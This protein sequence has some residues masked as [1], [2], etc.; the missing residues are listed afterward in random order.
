MDRKTLCHRPTACGINVF[1]H[2]ILYILCPYLRLKHRTTKRLRCRREETTIIT[3]DTKPQNAEP[4]TPD[5]IALL[6]LITPELKEQ[7]S[8]RSLEE[9]ARLADTAGFAAVFTATQARSTPDR[10]TYFGSGKLSEIKAAMADQGVSQVIV[11]GELSPTQIRNMEEALGENAQVIDRTMLI[12]DIFARHAT[13][14]E[15]K[16]QVEIARLR[17]TAPRL[18]GRGIEMSRMGGGT[19]SGF[20]AHRGGG[21]TKLETDRRHIR[22]R[23][24]TLTRELEDMKANRALVR[25]SRERSGLPHVA[26][27]GY[28]NCGK[29]TLL[30]K[31]TGAGVLAEDKLFATL[32]PTTRRLT[33]PG[34]ETVLL[35]DTVGFVR[36]LPHHLVE[37]FQSTLDEVKY[38]DLI[39]LLCDLS[40]SEHEDQLAVAHDLIAQLGAQDKPTLTVYNKIDRCPDAPQNPQG[41]DVAYI[42]AHS[43]Q[44]V[45]ELLQRIEKKLEETRRRVTFVFPVQNQAEISALYAGAHTLSVEYLEDSVH[46][47]ALVDDALLGRL[48]AFVVDGPPVE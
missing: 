24:D 21:E 29:S 2:W 37:A 31:L 44:G 35:T 23:I 45:G 47:V 43:G 7:E 8:E 25:R 39:V 10:A 33:L 1:Y 15:G 9:L 40:D 20:G 30:N 26:L 13:T 3:L 28:T 17:Y 22:R 16:I 14:S 48:R 36:R 34:G 4:F 6:G 12:L 41:R 18:T 38:A 42:S 5:P 32:D 27:V 46:V 11:D 19:A